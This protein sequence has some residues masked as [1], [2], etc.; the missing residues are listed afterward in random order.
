MLYNSTGDQW[1]FN[2]EVNCTTGFIGPIDGIIGGGTPAAGTFTT[3]IVGVDGA[4]AGDV[5]INNTNNGE[6]IWEGSTADGHENIL[7]AADG[8]GINT[9]PTGT[10]TLI[11]NNNVYDSISTTSSDDVASLTAVKAAYDR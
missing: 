11:S 9:L 5:T 3:L 1:E 2:K 6:I 8:A 4:T 7:R 10:G